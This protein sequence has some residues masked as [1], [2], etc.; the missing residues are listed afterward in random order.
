MLLFITL[1]RA[2]AACVITNSHYTG[3]YPTDAIANGGLLGDVLFFAVSGFCL[4]NPRQSFGRWYAHR[5]FRILPAVW[6]ATLVYAAVGFHDL[7]PFRDLIWPTRYHFVG[8]ILLLY[9]PFFGVMR[10]ECLKK[11]LP[12]VMLGVL[13]AELAVYVLAYDRSRYHIDDVH[14]PAILFLFFESMLLGAWFSLRRE[15]MTQRISPLS[16]ALALPLAGAYAASKLYF[17]KRGAR[18]DFQIANQAVLFALLA[19]LFRAAMGTERLLPRIPAQLFRPVAFLSTLT[20]EIYVVQYEL[21]PRIAPRLSF[22]LN[23]LAITAAI[24][25]SAWL[26]HLAAERLGRLENKIFRS[27]GSPTSP[28]AASAPESTP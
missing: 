11:R 28:T 5:L 21:I 24:L 3:V 4:A 12:W 22:P 16:M 9:I 6:I 27:S 17:S 1:L 26:V 23:W 13:A 7:S 2:L 20:L 10:A 25:A 18:L 15:K 8:S 19:A 14:E